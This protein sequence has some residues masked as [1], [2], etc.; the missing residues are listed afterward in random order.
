MP[1]TRGD[2][3]LLYVAEHVKEALKAPQLPAATRPPGEKI[4]CARKYG[5]HARGEVAN[6]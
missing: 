4:R 5:P 1:Q 6:L 3:S 2:P